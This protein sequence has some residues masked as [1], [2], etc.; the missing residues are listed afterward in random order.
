LEGPPTVFPADFS[1]Q[2]TRFTTAFGLFSK[3]L[4]VGFATPQRKAGTF[5]TS[6]LFVTGGAVVAE[7]MEFLD[8]VNMVSEAGISPH[9][10]Q[11]NHYFGVLFSG[12][13]RCLDVI[14][15]GNFRS[16]GPILCWS[17]A[18]PVIV[19]LRDICA[20]VFFQPIERRFD[21]FVI[22]DFE[23]II[24]E[25]LRLLIHLFDRQIPRAILPGGGLSRL[26]AE[27]VVSLTALLPLMR[28]VQNFEPQLVNLKRRIVTLNDGLSWAHDQFELPFAVD[29]SLEIRHRSPSF[30]RCL[31]SMA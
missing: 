30:A 15:N 7:W 6:A 14:T 26:K 11:L 19:R 16:A 18:K 3:Q 29:L 28:S 10:A 25:G 12:M 27:M 8:R 9:V 22:E 31:P 5:S 17:E 23:R 2:F 4:G 24:R 20:D 13:N 1:L 21:N